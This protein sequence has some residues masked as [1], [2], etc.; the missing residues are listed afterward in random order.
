MN[1]TYRGCVL[2]KENYDVV[3]I[4]PEKKYTVISKPSEG[5]KIVND[6]GADCVY[7]THIFNTVEPIAYTSYYNDRTLPSDIRKKSVSLG[8]P[9][10]FTGESIPQLN[11]RGYMLSLAKTGEYDKYTLAYTKEI[12][13][14]L[15]PHKII[16]L[17]KN[18]IILCHEVPSKFCHRHI[19]AQWLR[20]N[21]YEVIEWQH[22]L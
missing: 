16:V 18:T 1:N 7:P 3:G 5:L 20:D 4:T 10:Y 14:K 21:G 15:D 12:L 22:K 19:V 2:L 6:Y 13:Q 9:V 17:I 11:P 8:V